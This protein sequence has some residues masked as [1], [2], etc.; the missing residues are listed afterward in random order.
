MS[1]SQEFVVNIAITSHP[2]RL[3]NKH[4]FSLI[5][6]HANMKNGKIKCF[7]MFVAVFVTLSNELGFMI[8]V[9][10]ILDFFALTIQYFLFKQYFVLFHS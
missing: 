9:K 8:N 2:K 10:L 5:I 7:L 1:K 6:Y 3:Y 4:F